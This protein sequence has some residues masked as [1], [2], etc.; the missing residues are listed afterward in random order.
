MIKM[1]EIQ[2]DDR[3][4]TLTLMIESNDLSS[5]PVTPEAKWES[6]LIC[7]LNELQ[8]KHIPRTV[9]L[10]AIPLNT[11]A[12]SPIADFMNGNATQWNTMIRNLIAANPNGLRLKD[13]ENTLKMVDDSAL[14]KN[15]LHFN[16]QQGIQWINDAFQTKIEEMQIEVRMM[17]NP[18][19]RGSSASRVRSHV[20][21]P[22]ADRM[23][24][25][26]T[27]ANVVQ[28]TPSSNLREMLGTATAPRGWSLENRIG[29]IGGPPQRLRAPQANLQVR[30]RLLIQTV[31]E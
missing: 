15:G 20:P 7:L 27:E 16:T 9:C 11:N 10:C 25:L 1:M 17:V 12:G 23:G 8:Q 22:L 30:Q 3:V 21:Q 19:A 18:V 29:T 4:D 13:L 31:M 28:L 5:K 26:T 2:N 24:P 6:L 14:T